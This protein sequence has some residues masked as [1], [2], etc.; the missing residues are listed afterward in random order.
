MSQNK[1]THV[2]PW[3]L[4]YLLLIPLRKYSQDPQRILSPYVRDGMTVLEVGP[5]MGYFSLTLAQLVGPHGK[6]IC[7]DVQEKMLA[8]L[9][10][11]AQKA[12]VLDRITPIHTSEQSLL[13]KEYESK[14]DFTLALA[15]VHEVPDQDRLF[16]EINRSMKP[17]A[18]L[19]FSEPKGHVTQEDFNKALAIAQATGFKVESHVEIHRSQS[20]LLKK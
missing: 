11:R 5:G 2:C 20:V 7:V 8:K 14:I 3:W 18:L 9:R 1:K 10:T 4:G 12:G 13:I 16:E 15:V 17:G 6:V 19:L